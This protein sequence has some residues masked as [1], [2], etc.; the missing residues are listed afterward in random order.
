MQGTSRRTGLVAEKLGMTQV[1]DKEGKSIAVTVLR[2][3][4]N[5]VIANKTKEKNGY[6]SVVMGFGEAKPHRVSKSVKGICAKA[7]VKPTKIIKEFRVSDDAL[8]SAGSEILVTHYVPNQYIDI[9]GI[10]TGKGFAGGMKRWNFR[11]LEAS[12]GVSVSHRSIG[13]TGQRQDP[14]KT[15]KGKKMPGHLGAD[16]VTLQNIKIVRIDEELGLILVNGS[17]PGK[18]G[19]IVT[20]TDAVKLSM[21]ANVAYPAAVKQAAKAQANAEVKV[22]QAVE[23]E[24]SS[25]NQSA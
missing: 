15:F 1:F 13:S 24:V 23:A 19:S 20:I 16:T 17:V 2:A 14:G 21:P 8:V 3:N 6:T 7:N 12:H 9:H 18:K 25:D 4:G 10:S 5:T 22:E 11:G